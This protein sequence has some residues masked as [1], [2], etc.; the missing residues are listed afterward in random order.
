[1]SKTLENLNGTRIQDQSNGSRWILILLIGCLSMF[2]AEVFAGSSQIW[3]IDLWSLFITFPLYLCHLLFFLNLAIKTKKTSIPQLYLWGVLF[4]LYESWITKVLWA[5]YPGSDGPGFGLFLGIA[6]LEFSILVF[7]WHPILAFVM[8][9]LV[10]ESFTNL[11]DQS[12]NIENKIF[13]SHLPFLKSDKKNLIFFLFLILLGSSFLSL[14][15]GY[16]IFVVILAILGSVVLIYLFV[17]LGRKKNPHSFSIYSLQL[18]KKGFIIVSIYLISLYVI[19]FIFLLPYSIPNSAIPFLVIIGFYIFIVSMLFISKPIEERDSENIYS[20]E[21]I[22][23]S[24]FFFKLF[25]LFLLITIVFC[26]IF[27][28][29]LIIMFILYLGLGFFG[30]PIFFAFFLIKALKGKKQ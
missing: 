23:S 27:P 1:M 14:N 28:I 11:K 4:A 2:L 17:Q 5:G 15:T 18:G 6:I 24:N 25:G 12:R 20:S 30:G 16:N 9:I 3:F 21:D 22:F 13:I 7:F 19:T 10:F 26:I 8:P 29:S